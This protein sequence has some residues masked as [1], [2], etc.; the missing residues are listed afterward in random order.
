PI[1]K[2]VKVHSLRH[3]MGAVARATVLALAAAWSVPAAAS[4][5]ADAPLFTG[6]STAIK[7]NLMFILDDSGSMQ[8]DF[9]PDAADTL[10]R[11]K[12]GRTSAH[13]NGLAYDPDQTYPAPWTVDASNN[14]VSRG[15]ANV[16]TFTTANPAE[17]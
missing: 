2:P 6:S 13:C 4:S 16:S 7:P 3:R 14:V 17:Q 8:W 1:M 12:F 9:M 10:N 11:L 15:D 5:L